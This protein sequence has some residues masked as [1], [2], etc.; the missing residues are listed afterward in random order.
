[1]VTVTFDSVTPLLLDSA[2]FGDLARHP[3]VGYDAARLITRYR[4]LTDT[5]LTLGQ[6]VRGDVI[7]ARQAE[8][9]A[10]Y[11]RPSPGVTGTDY[12]FISSKVLK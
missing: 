2:S 1:M 12:E 9:M 7:T 10:P 5:P 11:V 6:M 3:Y 8:Q 4:S